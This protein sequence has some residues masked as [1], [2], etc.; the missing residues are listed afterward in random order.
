MPSGS[1]QH[2]S[3]DVSR[4]WQATILPLFDRASWGL[5]YKLYY[6]IGVKPGAELATRNVLGDG[7]WAKRHDAPN[8]AARDE[9]TNTRVSNGCR[10]SGRTAPHLVHCRTSGPAQQRDQVQYHRRTTFI[11]LDAAQR[12]F[13]PDFTQPH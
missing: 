11:A 4:G 13:A 10:F 9:G 8:N 7:R 12:P 5:N 1:V 3:G 6:N 2:A